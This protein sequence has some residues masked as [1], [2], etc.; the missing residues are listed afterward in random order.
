MRLLH[1]S[2][3][4]FLSYREAD[5]DLTQI[6]HTS[7]TGENGSGKSTIPL[8]IAWA[9]FGTVRVS[10]IATSVIRDE[11]DETS[12]TLDLQD[13]DGTYWRIFRNLSARSGTTINL[14]SSEDGEEW[15]RYG[16][17]LQATAKTKIADIVRLDEDTF[18][19][20]MLVDQSSTSGGTRFTRADAAVRRDIL[21]SLV[22]ELGQWVSYHNEVSE[23]LRVQNR[24]IEA[25]EV[26][27]A[28]TKAQI[29]QSKIKI[30]TLTTKIEDLDEESLLKEEQK[31]NGR[32]E[33]VTQRLASSQ[34][35]ADERER[36]QKDV[37]SE[38][39][40]ASVALERQIDALEHKR[41]AKVAQRRSQDRAQRL[42]AGSEEERDEIRASLNA[43][44]DTESYEKII[45]E[46]DGRIER[47]KKKLDDYSAERVEIQT[48][49][50]S[51]GKQ[52]SSL[53]TERDHGSGTCPVCSSE[54][55]EERCEELID[56]IRSEVLGLAKDEKALV[57]KIENVNAKL[58]DAREDRSEAR[59]KLA[60]IREDQKRLKRDLTFIDNQIQ[61]R[62]ETLEDLG[63]SDDEEE[64]D[65]D[66]EIGKLSKR[67]DVIEEKR[68]ADILAIASETDDDEE[69][70]IKDRKI[71]QDLKYDLKANREDQSD[72]HKIKGAHENETET[73]D[74]KKTLL[75]TTKKS[76]KTAY[77]RSEALSWLT[78]A[79]SQK[80]APGMLLDSVLGSIEDEQNRIL[81]QLSVGMPMSV[82]FRQTRPNKTNDRVKEVLDIIVHTGS[83]V[84]RPI[85]SFS[86]G[87]RVLLSLS[88]VFAMV[89][90]FNGMNPGLVRTIFL[91]EP[92]GSLDQIRVPA[93]VDVIQTVMSAGIVDSMWIITHDDKV[94]D[95][96]PQQISVARDEGGESVM[97]IR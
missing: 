82:E 58:A 7:V 18:Y 56:S 86:F 6:V 31:L 25:L 53:E 65:Y 85:E 77:Q 26:Q 54:L 5:I 75:K 2:I 74:S 52:T 95:A 23:E 96:L 71:L 32:I 4:D 40:E 70:T 22:P 49:S 16:D 30:K 27:Q 63:S 50:K 66:K 10:S 94:I 1:L 17:H 64:V 20:L 38:A 21:H 34:S 45:E 97:T 69:L 29:E 73:L 51:L 47:L 68:D 44:E 93:F 37:R 15:V 72:L 42:L 91:D 81:S 28:Q 48:K 90:V 46:S 60:R 19:S 57:V 78:K 80:G 92:L 41:D 88:N 24:D 35:V 61:E 84:E 3:R 87:E 62:K 55:T 83:G 13:E 43:L 89:K 12:V 39:R 59:D 79:V 11:A 33:K 8:A 36:R 9:L 14:L 67:I 76:L